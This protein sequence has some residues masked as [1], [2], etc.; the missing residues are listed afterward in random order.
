MS[1]PK[2][3]RHVAILTG[4]PKLNAV[5]PVHEHLA[6]P[7][8]TGASTREHTSTLTALDEQS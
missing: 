3:V 8:M 4:P 7:Q 6:P 5:R 1:D 2:R